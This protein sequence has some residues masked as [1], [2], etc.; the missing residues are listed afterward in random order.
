MLWQTK[1][2]KHRPVQL[3]GWSYE[4]TRMFIT[5]HWIIMSGDWRVVGE[6]KTKP[7]SEYDIHPGIIFPIPKNWSFGSK[8]ININYIDLNLKS[9]EQ[10]L[11]GND[12]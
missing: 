6:N 1:H 2:Q 12:S 4:I 10:T 3:E 8:I 9:F 7:E 5:T 11:H